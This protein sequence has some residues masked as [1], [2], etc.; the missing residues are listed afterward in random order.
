MLRTKLQESRR[1]LDL[2][3]TMLHACQ[4]DHGQQLDD[5]ATAIMLRRRLLKLQPGKFRFRSSCSKPELRLRMACLLRLLGF[6]ILQTSVI[7]LGFS[8]NE[9]RALLSGQHRERG[10][11]KIRLGRVRV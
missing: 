7:M 8:C 4:G 10:T 6:F 11:W 2:S 5:G 3:V 1:P 9:H